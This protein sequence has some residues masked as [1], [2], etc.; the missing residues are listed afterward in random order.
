MLL[1]E[2]VPCLELGDT[3][4]VS[5]PNRNRLTDLENKFMVT[6]GERLQEERD[7]LR[8]SD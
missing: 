5:L 4:I 1:S 3:S 6:R 7:K 8:A 2:E